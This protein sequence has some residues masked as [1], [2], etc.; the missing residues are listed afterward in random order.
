MEDP[1]NEERKSDLEDDQEDDDRY[2]FN[3]DEEAAGT[4]ADE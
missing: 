2:L 4:D 3:E 1:L